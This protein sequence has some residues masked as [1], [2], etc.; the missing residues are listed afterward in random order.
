[1]HD[2]IYHKKGDFQDY[3]CSD[4][5][6]R[7]ESY[8]IAAMHCKKMGEVVFQRLFEMQS[9][10]SDHLPKDDGDY[11]LRLEQ[12]GPLFKPHTPVVESILN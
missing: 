5:R 1:M 3:T 8:S 2:V 6:C 7:I 11:L 9:T 12:S 10:Y 4:P